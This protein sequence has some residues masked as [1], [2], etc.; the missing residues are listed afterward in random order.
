MGILSPSG[1]GFSQRLD[2]QALD[3]ERSHGDALTGPRS[4]GEGRERDR[5]HF[6]DPGVSGRGGE[7]L[8][9]L[10][11][12]GLPRRRTDEELCCLNRSG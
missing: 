3:A 7:S 8:G 1:L 2:L 10:P 11:T 12:G 6:G 4:D 9:R 5:F